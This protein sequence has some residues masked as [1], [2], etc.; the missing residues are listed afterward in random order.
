MEKVEASSD[1]IQ[2][3][4]TLTD[5]LISAAVDLIN[6]AVDDQDTLVKEARA[7]LSAWFTRKT[8]TLD[9]MPKL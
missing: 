2:R 5:S 7:F 3:D 8:P 1:A 4:T 6:C 9:G